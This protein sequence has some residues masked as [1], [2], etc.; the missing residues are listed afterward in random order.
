[1]TDELKA[2]PYIA[3]AEPVLRENFSTGGSSDPHQ[4]MVVTEGEPRKLESPTSM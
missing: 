4:M 2:D 1:M 3:K